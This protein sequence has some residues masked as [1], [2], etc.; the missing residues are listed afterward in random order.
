MLIINY[1]LHVYKLTVATFLVFRVSFHSMK[2]VT[3]PPTT[4][5]RTS[6]NYVHGKNLSIT[7]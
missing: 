5:I 2:I 3:V 6:A 7:S 4:E 1:T